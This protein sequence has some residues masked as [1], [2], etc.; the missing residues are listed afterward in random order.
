MY[1]SSK[2]KRKTIRLGAKDDQSDSEEIVGGYDPKV[3]RI[4]ARVERRGDE[5]WRTEDS[6]D[7]SSSESE[8]GDSN[9]EDQ[10]PLSSR[11]FFPAATS[12]GIEEEKRTA[13]EEVEKSIN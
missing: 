8:N 13:L 10:I 11:G 2:S 6:E 4:L 9:W 12:T 5:T 3:R 1:P 7:D